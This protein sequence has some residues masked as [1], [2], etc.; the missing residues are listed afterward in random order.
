MKFHLAI[1]T[2]FVATAWNSAWAYPTGPGQCISGAASVGIPHLTESATTGFLQDAG[3]TMKVITTIVPQGNLL[4]VGNA[5]GNAVPIEIAGTTK[6]FKGVLLQV[7]GAAGGDSIIQ[8]G[9]FL[10]LATQGQGCAGKAAVGHV[11]ASVKN[12]VTARLQVESEA[13][14]QVEVTVVTNL[15]NGVS[16][17]YY[18]SFEMQLISRTLDELFNDCVTEMLAADANNDEI[19]TINEYYNFILGMGEDRCYTGSGQLTTEQRDVFDRYAC[20]YCVED[21]GADFDSCC[22]NPQELPI[23]GVQSLGSIAASDRS[24]L[25]TVC[26]FSYSRIPPSCEDSNVGQTTTQPTQAPVATPATATPTAQPVAMPVAT[27]QPVAMPA[28]I[29]PTGQ[30]VAISTAAP[31]AV[32]T[33]TLTVAPT[34]APVTTSAPTDTPTT[35]APTPAPTTAAP[36]PAPTSAAPTSAPTTMDYSDCYQS[37]VD[38]NSITIDDFLN[39]VEFYK[40]VVGLGQS[41]C[42]SPAVDGQLTSQQKAV[43]TA[44]ACMWCSEQELPF[45]PCCTG[46]DA[47]VSV[48]GATDPANATPDQLNA[49]AALCRNTDQSIYSSCPTSAPVAPT[50]APVVPPTSVPTLPG[51]IPPRKEVPDE[52]KDDNSKLFGSAQQEQN[53]GNLN[54]R[55]LKM[56]GE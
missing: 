56:R 5:V 30:P 52:S 15:S 1:V 3:Y 19:L 24:R 40:F 8:P 34:L 28:T 9:A 50:N 7:L 48:A 47:K 51:G 11:D 17:Y 16:E 18:S 27:V 29:T 31:V 2:L 6:G 45:D 43:F 4:T 39:E 38:A 20:S 10:Q 33:G 26:Q 23:R 53:R 49:L 41:K 44:F 54:R 36:T 25:A 32:P 21:T 37:I 12:A 55:K 42:Y 46:P 14:T 22:L 13:V 35:P